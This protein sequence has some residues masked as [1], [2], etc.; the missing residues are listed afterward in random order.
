M[1]IAEAAI[2]ALGEDECLAELGEIMDQRFPVL[3]EDL[4]SDGNLEHDRLAVWAVAILA[5]SI[6]ALRRVE[7]LLIAVIDQGV[8]PVDDLDD[9]V[10]AASAIAA[11]RATELDELLA[12]ERNTA[13]AAV[14]GADI[15][16]GFIEEFHG[17]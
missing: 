4:G 3:V 16:L 7:V 6:G 2:A 17:L 12:P 5:H 8:E 11:G 9:D 1:G 14:A 15:D 13:V 10:T